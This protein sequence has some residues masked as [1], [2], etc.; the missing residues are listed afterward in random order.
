MHDL[1]VTPLQESG[2]DCTERGHPL[3][4]QPSSKGDSMLLCNAHVK[5][6]AVEA[7]LEA[8]HA[9]AATHGSM[10]ANDAAVPLCFSY[11]SV[12]KEVSVGCN[13]HK[14]TAWSKSGTICSDMMCADAAILSLCLGKQS[15]GK[16]VDVRCYWRS[17][18]VQDFAQSS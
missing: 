7:L 12:G 1:V 4:R 8:V 17:S 5:G 16:E 11:Q 2:I 15:I 13:L 18:A 10:H 9:C 14:H 6:A 3:A